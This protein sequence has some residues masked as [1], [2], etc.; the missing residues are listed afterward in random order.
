[1]K[2]KRGRL[3]PCHMAG[4]ADVRRLVV[5]L[6][7]CLLFTGVWIGCAPRSRYDLSYA[8][9]GFSATVSGQACRTAPVETTDASPMIGVDTAGTPVIVAAIVTVGAPRGAA[10]GGARDMCVVFTAP[11]AL[12]GMT[13]TVTAADTAADGADGGDGADVGD[14]ARIVTVRQGDLAVTAPAGGVYDGLLTLARVCF[15]IGD[16]VSI[17]P[18]SE[19][20]DGYTV[21]LSAAAAVQRLTFSAG[22][23]AG[24]MPSRIRYE[25]E[26]GWLD[27]TVA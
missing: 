4:A 13:V 22:A 10:A 14:G 27:L 20:E 2:K 26:T 12:A 18:M 8:D 16:V 5:C 19:G 23:A 3:W 11:D 17:S 7:A 21:T 25:D 9:G 15:P 1:M 6:A 24:T